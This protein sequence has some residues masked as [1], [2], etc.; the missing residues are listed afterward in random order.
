MVSTCESCGCTQMKLEGISFHRYVLFYTNY[1]LES[2]DHD[3]VKSYIIK[4][5]RRKTIAM[6]THSKSCIVEAVQK[7]L[8]I[9]NKKR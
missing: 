4:K 8:G 6:H 3:S 9:H 7:S 2:L 1:N 5:N